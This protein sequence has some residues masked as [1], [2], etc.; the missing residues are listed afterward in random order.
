MPTQYSANRALLRLC[1]QTVQL[2]STTLTLT[3]DTLK[4]KDAAAATV[5]WKTFTSILDFCALLLELLTRV[6]CTDGWPDNKV[7]GHCWCL[8]KTWIYPCAWRIKLYIYNCM[9]EWSGC[10]LG[11]TFAVSALNFSLSSLLWQW[12]SDAAGLQYF[13]PKR[14]QLYEITI[15]SLRRLYIS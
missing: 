2:H 10:R 11:L 6:E 15:S 1:V 13:G 9:H 8:I 5:P 12:P 4:L 7:M 3:L 14:K